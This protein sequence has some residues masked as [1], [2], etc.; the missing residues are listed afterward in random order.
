M[1]GNASDPREWGDPAVKHGIALMR[2]RA[3][4][5]ERLSG[6]ALDAFQRIAAPDLS[7]H[8]EYAA[9]APREEEAFLRSY[10]RTAR[11][12]FV[13]AALPPGPS[14]RPRA[15]ISGHQV[16]GVASQGSIAP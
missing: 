2:Y 1:R 7:L 14:R 15:S 4:A 9:G 8:A 16:R 12:I 6:R 5:A 3:E 10:G 11:A 13:E